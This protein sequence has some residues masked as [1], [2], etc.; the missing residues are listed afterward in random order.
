VILIL[1]SSLRFT[2]R[3][4]RGAALPD[5]KRR[6]GRASTACQWSLGGFRGGFWTFLLT[7]NPPDGQHLADAESP[8]LPI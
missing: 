1:D 3:A 7:E 5:Y 8:Q 6:P 2:S 4:G